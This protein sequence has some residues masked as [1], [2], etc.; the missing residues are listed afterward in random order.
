MIINR[1]AYSNIPDRLSFTLGDIVH[2]EVLEAII[3]VNISDNMAP[4]VAAYV[5]VWGFSGDGVDEVSD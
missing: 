1:E 5:E 3:F 4:A 2:D